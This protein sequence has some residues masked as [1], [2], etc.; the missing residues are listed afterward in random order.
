MTKTTLMDFG[1]IFTFENCDGGECEERWMAYGMPKGSVPDQYVEKCKRG[2]RNLHIYR[3]GSYRWC[4]KCDQRV[5]CRKYAL[6]CGEQA[7]L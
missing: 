6:C 7:E 1:I 2:A 3:L 5:N 4:W